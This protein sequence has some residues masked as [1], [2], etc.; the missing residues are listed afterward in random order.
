MNLFRWPVDVWKALLSSLP[1]GKQGTRTISPV[2]LQRSHHHP[3]VLLRCHHG[4]GGGRRFVFQ[5]ASVDEAVLWRNIAA[6]KSF[7]SIGHASVE[8]GLKLQQAACSAGL[9]QVPRPGDVTFAH[10]QHDMRQV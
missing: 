5:D 9:F 6:G 2:E 7:V 4:G 3:L 8:P 10:S 1:L